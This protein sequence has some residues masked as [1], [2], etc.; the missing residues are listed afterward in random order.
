[1]ASEY[2]NI[3][4]V[5]DDANPVWFSGSDGKYNLKENTEGSWLGK[6]EFSNKD[7]RHRIEPWLTSLFQSE[8]LSLI[9]GSGLTHAVHYLAAQKGAAGMSA[10]TLSNHQAEINQA[11]ER[12][13]EAA[14]RKK[15]NLEDQLRVANE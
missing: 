5:R 4:K 9:A 12:A 3:L 2:K 8:H 11:A 15:G 7:L 1:M 14:G 10:L 6:N 13:S